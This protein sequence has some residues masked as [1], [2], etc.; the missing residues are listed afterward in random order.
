MLK[1]EV[2]N[3][4]KMKRIDE[5][6]FKMLRNLIGYKHPQE[7]Q[8]QRINQFRR[9]LSSNKYQTVLN[10]IRNSSD[11]S[12]LSNQAVSKEYQIRELLRQE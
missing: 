8:T 7:V 12:A 9:N 11:V 5:H 2:N 1:K 6:E 10:K 3:L 4:F